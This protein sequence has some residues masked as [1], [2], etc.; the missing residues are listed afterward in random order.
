MPNS[1]L[2]HGN[3]PN[4]IYFVISTSKEKVRPYFCDEREMKLYLYA[5][6]IC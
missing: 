1:Y 2:V 6:D 4:R 3:L 5:L